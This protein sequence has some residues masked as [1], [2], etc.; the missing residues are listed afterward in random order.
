MTEREW[1][2]DSD[3]TAVH[4]PQ[5]Y[6]PT[7]EQVVQANEQL[8]IV[9]ENKKNAEISFLR[10]A[11]A[12]D[13]VE[14]NQLYKAHGVP[15]FRAWVSSP[16]VDLSYRLASDLLRIVREVLPILPEGTNIP[17]VSTLRE[18]LPVLGDD[19]GKEKFVEALHEV[20][21][22]TVVDTRERIK[23]LRGIARPIDEP[24]PAVF[25]ARVRMGEAF[26]RVEITCTTGV[27]QYNVGVLTIRREHW[28]RFESRFGA[29]I[30]FETV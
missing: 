19:Q 18:L 5:V 8:H 10:M 25:K 4:Y 12:L 7:P 15:S 24:L 27:D 2:I 1:F 26:H 21:G 16:N 13:V 17:S 22:L 11:Q 20:E 6:R 14:K 29:F 30:E 9:L 3:G 23:E 28:P